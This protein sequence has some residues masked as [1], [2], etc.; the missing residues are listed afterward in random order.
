MVMYLF[1]GSIDFN[2]EYMAL[3]RAIEDIENSLRVLS[4]QYEGEFIIDGQL[5]V[6]YDIQRYVMALIRVTWQRKMFQENMASLWHSQILSTFT[7]NDKGSLFDYMDEEP[8]GGDLLA[9]RFLIK[10]FL[11]PVV[12]IDK[13]V[14]DFQSDWESTKRARVVL[15]VMKQMILPNRGDDEDHNTLL[16][17]KIMKV[18]WD[19]NHNF[20]PM[21]LEI[22]KEKKKLAEFQE[23]EIEQIEKDTTG[24][25]KKFLPRKRTRSSTKKQKYPIV[26]WENLHLSGQLQCITKSLE[27]IEAQRTTKILSEMLYDFDIQVLV[28][29]INGSKKVHILLM[30][31]GIAIHMLTEKKYPLSQKMMSKMLSKRLE[32]DQESTQAYELLRF[33]RSQ[34]KK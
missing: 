24:K 33:I 3:Y 29:A 9:Q 15:S 5:Y 27:E 16:L 4:E 22:D 18:V 34:V 17:L 20:V 11:M 21:D 25:R 14:R 26:D 7:S 19:F 6:G 32:V 8:H 10:G 1:E 12:S 28:G 30:Q 23:I 13:E 31:N 2:V